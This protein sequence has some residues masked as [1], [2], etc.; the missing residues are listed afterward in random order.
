[1][2]DPFKDT[3]DPLVINTERNRVQ[4]LQAERD[5]YRKA[6]EEISD[7]IMLDKYEY[8]RIAHKALNQ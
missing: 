3:R 4:T 6:L 7:N 1:M 2:S 8:R 5:R